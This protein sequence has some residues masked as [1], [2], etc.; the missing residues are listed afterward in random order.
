MDRISVEEALRAPMTPPRAAI[1]IPVHNRREITLRCLDAL[2]GDGIPAWADIYVVDDGSTD[3]TAAAV[4]AR[5]PSAIIVRGNGD[6]WW[7]GA[8]VAG[9]KA[10]W[11]HGTQLFIWL[12]DDC[13][14]APGA[15][16]RLCAAA[17]EHR[18]IA[19]GICLLPGSKEAVYGGLER[20]GFGF[21][22]RPWR[23]GVVEP[24]EALCGNL[25]CVPRFAVERLG[26]PDAKHFP[27]A[28]A[29][30]DFTLRAHRS[31]IPVEVVHDAF[32]HAAP[33]AW[34]NHASWLCSDIPVSAIWRSLWDKRSYG[35]LPSQ[36]TLYVR[37]WGWRGGVHVTWLLA[38]RVPVTLLCLVLPLDLRR[39]FWG[40]R[41]K[42]WQEEQRLRGAIAHVSSPSAPEQSEGS[43]RAR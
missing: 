38:K 27:H 39:R 36:W 43:P 17:T 24:C 22:L 34:E 25:V 15:L 42:A 5:L 28:H 37:H 4:A 31:G 18:A 8:I 21:V 6:W 11:P 16:A 41:S 10:A 33:N 1:I 20:R 23:P 40:R 35:Y 12:N 29:D 2:M 19:G 3:G 30:L 32:A 13:R 14:P 26:F 9:M 7:G